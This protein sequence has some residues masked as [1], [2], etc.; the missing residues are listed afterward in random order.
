MRHCFVVSLCVFIAAVGAATPGVA[1]DRAPTHAVG[2]VPTGPLAGGVLAAAQAATRS[3]TGAKSGGAM[4]A[5]GMELALLYYQHQRA[6]AGGVQRLRAAAIRGA[7]GTAKDARRIGARIHHP[8][9]A[10]GESVTVEAVASEGTA[11]LLN[12]LRGLGLDRGAA[13]GNLVSGRLPIRSIRA[14]AQLRELRGMVPAYAHLRVGRVGSEADTAHGVFSV[15]DERDLDGTG[16]KVCVLSDSYNRSTQTVTSASDDVQT[17]DLPGADN[18]VGRTTPVDVLDDASGTDE[19]RAMLQLIHD[20]APGAALGF[21][22][23]VGGTSVFASGIRDLATTGNC[24]VI[25]DDI[26]YN[27]EPFYQ[28]GPVSNAVDDVVQN[29]GVAY[30]SAAGN[31]GQNS[32]EAPFR[33][34]GQAGIISGSATRHDFDPSA[35]TDTRQDIAIAPGGFFRIFSFQWTDP[36]SIVQGSAGADTDLDIALVDPG[37]TVAVESSD[38]SDTDGNGLPV[39]SL[40]FTNNGSTTRRLDLVI[41]KAAGPDPDS[42]KYVYFAEG[43]EITEY[44][45]KGATIFGHPM[46]EGAMAVAAAPFFETNAYDA[47]VDPARL[48]SFSSKGGLSILFDQSGSPLP[49]PEV[50]KKPDVTGVDFIDNTFFGR[51]L[52]GSIDGDSF[53]NF[54]GTSAAAPNVAAIAALMRQERDLTPSEVYNQLEGNALDITERRNDQGNVES[55]ASGW[56]PWSGHGF[57]E[58]K[59]VFADVFDIQIAEADASGTPLEL[60]WRVREGVSIQSYNIDRRYFGEGFTALATP[61]GSPVQFSNPGLGVY[62]YRIGW[63]RTDGS[64]GTQTAVDTVGFR[65]VTATVN[66]QGEGRRQSIEVEGTL[67]PGTRETFSYR[68]ERRPGIAGDFRSLDGSMPMKMGDRVRFTADRQPTGT[69][70]YRIRATDDQGNTIASSA[71][72]VETGIGPYPNPAR[73]TVTINL[74]TDV[75]QSVQVQVY[76]ELG[77]RVYANR[78][79]LAGGAATKFTIDVGRWSSGVYFLRLRGETFTK[80]RKFI[81][82]R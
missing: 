69:Q 54:A 70:F 15:R 32:Y 11:P 2:Q 76:D 22:T 66:F 72:S 34:S 38:N 31:D 20:L 23:A 81:V 46:A 5:V 45:T 33:N 12:A 16:E 40:S 63:T 73:S 64:T 50:R 68:G 27:I 37:G 13:A 47:S 1:Q 62:T 55:I 67:P 26:G 51:D 18:P 41:E 78:R 49:S 24:S 8:V 30:F 58:A 29:E 39:E 7:S 75:S 74:R 9:S 14:A 28:D 25:V 79:A 17:G 19:G 6:G 36:S 21:H 80:V 43:A 77:R 53:P 35:G 52:S 59:R 10:D 44:D 4:G 65:D 56:D 3:P 48:N 57:V 82:R 71:A 60:S 61:G 42:V